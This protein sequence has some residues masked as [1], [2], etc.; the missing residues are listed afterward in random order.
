MLT[1]AT[2]ASCRANA[3]MATRSSIT[4]FSTFTR[5]V[6]AVAGFSRSCMYLHV[7]LIWYSQ[8]F[9]L[10]LI[11]ENDYKGRFLITLEKDPSH[12]RDHMKMEA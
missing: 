8:D 6:Q 7:Y 5:V 4:K 1:E 10:A 9:Q 12:A 2:V 11:K 3:A